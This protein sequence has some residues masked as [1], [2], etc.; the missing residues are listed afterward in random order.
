MPEAIQAVSYGNNRALLNFLDALS[1][2]YQRIRTAEKLQYGC[3]IELA[4]RRKVTLSVITTYIPASHNVITQ[5][6]YV[7][8]IYAMYAMYAYAM[9]AM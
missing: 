3:F 1:E 7:L 8:S 9:Y 4:S 5:R 6:K 2:G